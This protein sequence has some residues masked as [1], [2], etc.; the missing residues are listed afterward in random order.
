VLVMAGTIAGFSATT[1]GATFTVT[2]T[3]DSGSDS[4]RDAITKANSTPGTD[5]I[6]FSIPVGSLTNGV[7]VITVGSLLP[8]LTDAGTTIDGTTQTTNVG[9]TNPG[10]LGTGGVV[11]VDALPLPQ[12]NAPE[13]EIVDGN[14]LAV[15]LRPFTVITGD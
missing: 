4:L 12:V 11:G 7:A 8:A 6:A 14:G 9:D 3:N 13:V 5:T 15:G 2:N 10:V 1:L